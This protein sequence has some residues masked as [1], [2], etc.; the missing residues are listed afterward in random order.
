MEM[1]LNRSAFCSQSIR[2]ITWRKNTIKLP[3]ETSAEKEKCSRVLNYEAFFGRCVVRMHPEAAHDACTIAILCC[4]WLGVEMR[5]DSRV[6]VLLEEHA[7]LSVA[8]LNSQQST[9]AQLK[10]I[11]IQATS[12]GR[13]CI[14][15]HAPG[16]LILVVSGDLPR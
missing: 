14:A 1:T 16:P 5:E 6:G 7:H 11:L 12:H 9:Q 8:Q 2:L 13:P 4:A 15:E 10:L 3:T